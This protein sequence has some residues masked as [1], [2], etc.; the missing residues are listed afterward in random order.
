MKAA[1]VAT[2]AADQDPSNEQTWEGM[3]QS[4]WAGFREAKE[5]IG[6]LM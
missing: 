1:G 4:F 3:E 6:D 2:A 5:G